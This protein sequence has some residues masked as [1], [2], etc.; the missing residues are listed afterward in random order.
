MENK[1]INADCFNILPEIE[2][3]SIDC[4]LTDPPYGV[5]AC[6]WDIQPNLEL[7]FYEFNRIIKNDGQIIIFSQQPF[8]TDL[9]NANRKNFKYEIIYEKAKPVGFLNVNIRPLQSHENILIFNQKI[10][11]NIIK[12][13]GKYYKT[14]SGSKSENYKM[15]ARNITAGNMRYK[16]TIFRYLINNLTKDK[17]GLH[18]TQKP[19]LL[20]KDLLRMYSN[21]NDLILDPF[22]G[23][24]VLAVA[25]HET[26]RNFI[27]I[28]KELEYYEKSLKRYKQA[29]RQLLLTNAE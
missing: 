5:T 13:K 12:D 8:T 1:I 23:S 19:L 9:I 10:K 25:A 20:V 27:C 7:M 4:I 28:E 22:S 17:S 3:N 21:E 2:D 29:S 11:Y 14:K 16:K 6:K 18:P 24:G 26:K 15:Y